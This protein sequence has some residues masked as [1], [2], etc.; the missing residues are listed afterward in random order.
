MRDVKSAE[1]GG[2]AGAVDWSRIGVSRWR[3][4]I[5]SMITFCKK[6]GGALDETVETCPDCGLL[7]PWFDQA[8]ESVQQDGRSGLSGMLFGLFR[9]NSHVERTLLFLGAIDLSFLLIAF[10]SLTATPWSKNPVSTRI[11]DVGLLVL[12][13]GDL[14]LAFYSDLERPVWR[15]LA[16][17]FAAVNILG[18]LLLIALD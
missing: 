15:A 13:V 11:S 9:D 10:L 4:D 5:I 3:R 18:F 12:G 17:G 14:A 2:H 16:K 8:S 7:N 1:S 6:C